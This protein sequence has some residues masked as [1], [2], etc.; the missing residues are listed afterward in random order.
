MNA[1]KEKLKYGERNNI[2]V[3]S[4]FCFLPKVMNVF[5]VLEIIEA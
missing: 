1:T 3:E 5:K 2:T 4:Y